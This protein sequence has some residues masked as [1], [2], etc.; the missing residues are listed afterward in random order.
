MVEKIE[1]FLKQLRWKAYFYENKDQDNTEGE[2]KNFTFK[3][4]YTP[5]QNELLS[6]FE[7]DMYEL[8]RNIE[9]REKHNDFPYKLEDDVKNIKSCNNML[10]FAD[11]KKI[12]KKCQAMSIANCS[13]IISRRL[14]KNL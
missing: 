8:L 9:F 5:P 10:V 4:N 7:D 3:S 14:I 6:P 11:K 12:Y 1:N 13:T 2:K